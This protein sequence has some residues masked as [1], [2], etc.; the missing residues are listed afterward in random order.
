MTVKLSILWLPK[1]RL[2]SDPII[3]IYIFH[4]CYHAILRQKNKMTLDENIQDINTPKTN[5]WIVL[6][7]MILHHVFAKIENMQVCNGV[8]L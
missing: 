7:S 8:Q 2:T 4:E 3:Y 5:L 6:L 1:S